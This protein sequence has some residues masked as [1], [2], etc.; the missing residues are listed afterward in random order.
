MDRQIIWTTA[1]HLLRRKFFTPGVLCLLALYLLT[2]SYVTWDRWHSYQQQREIRLEHQRADRESWESNP[3]KHPHRMA[4]FG[5]FAFRQPHPLSIFDA[6]LENYMGNVIFLEAHKQN[7]ANFSEASL[8]TGLVRFGTLDGSMLM[9]L[10]LPLFIFFIGYNVVSREREG[11]TLRLMHVQGASMRDIL[12]GKS[13]GL[14]LGAAL[15]FV[16]ALLG[17]WLTIGLDD[18]SL[19]HEMALRLGLL[20]A[21]YVAFYAVLALA[22][23]LVS[24]W[25]ATSN[26]AL[27]TLLGAW[28]ILFV[29]LPRSAEAIG[30]ALVPSPSKLAFKEAIEEELTKGGDPHNPNDPHF[31]AIRDSLLRAYDVDDVKKLPFNYGGYLMGLGEERTSTIYAEH[32]ARLVDTYRAQSRLSYYLSSLSPYMALRQVSS[33]LS[34]TDFETYNGFLLQSEDYRYSLAQYM[35]R[36][37]ME[38]IASH[39]LGSTEGRVNVVSKDMFAAMPQFAFRYTTVTEVLSSELLP[40]VALLLMLAGL[41]SIVLLTYRRTPIL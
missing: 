32:Q 34:G 22:T 31:S 41:L 30:S 37:Q 14:W 17:M 38:H 39:A 1:S 20:T 25:S 15:F 6:G 35:N 40:V 33:G 3:D 8:S 7:T 28:L 12:L 27:L 9:G 10:I 4:H 13:L 26:H 36:L 23:V 18:P 11:R 29:V 16:P 24:A 5:A 21:G 19:H 2:Y